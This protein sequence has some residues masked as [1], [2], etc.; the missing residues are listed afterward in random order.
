MPRAIRHIFRLLLAACLLPA[1]WGF[2]WGEPPQ[3]VLVLNSYD[4]GYAW[5]DA[6]MEGVRHVFAKEAPDVELFFEYMSTKRHP[7]ALSFPLLHDLYAGRY[8]AQPPDLVL[9][10][11]D[12]ALDFFLAYRNELFPGTPGVF[13]GIN[14]FRPQRLG[15]HGGV[16]GVA[17]DIAPE[18][19]L[20]LAA[21]LHPG[22]RE[23]FLVSDS[24]ATG[25]INLQRVL[26]VAPMFPDLRFT[27]LSG[28]PLAALQEKLAGLGRES[29]VLHLSLFLDGS[30]QPVS[31][32]EVQRLYR[33][34]A[35][36]PVY[37]MW[38]F[39]V[40]GAVLGG[41]VVSGRNQ[42]ESAARLALRVLAGE[43]PGDI[44]VQD[45]PNAYIFSHAALQRLAIP[46][47][48]L[49]EG[50]VVKGRPL[51]FY[52]QYK[53]LTWAAAGVFV[54]MALLVLGLGVNIVRRRRAEALSRICE[55]RFQRVF[56]SSP[57][58]VAISRY[59]DGR[60]L[61]VNDAFCRLLEYPRDKVLGETPETLGNWERPED[62]H[63]CRENLLREGECHGLETMLL[64]R[65][66]RS[67]PVLLSASLIDFGG[68]TCVLSV[69]NDITE[70]K[71]DEERLK[72]SLME[73]DILLKE[74]HHRVKNNLQ[75][76]SS[77]LSL[78]SAHVCDPNDYKLFLESRNRIG[79]MAL[80]HEE[81]YK[82]TDLS[83]V[84]VADYAGKLLDRLLHIYGRQEAV[85]ADVRISGICLPINL[86][87]P[88][89][90]IVNELATNALQHA[91]VHQEAGT[92]FL[93]LERR[94]AHFTLTVADDGSGFPPG[95]DMNKADTLGLQLVTSLVKQLRGAITLDRTAGPLAG[96]DGATGTTFT[97]HFSEGAQ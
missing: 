4:P 15:G 95:L 71:M 75:I 26:A 87:I 1:L 41:K 24:T 58:A 49:P 97:I 73:K 57:D 2:A 89:G 93:A 61:A 77:L 8:T 62:R 82:S 59:S 25:R 64:S 66:G 80:V 11:D 63:H 78:Q 55:E 79:S 68:E 56:Q 12:N 65:H 19:T 48:S 52:S 70:R 34:H 51:T 38:D 7:P 47:S 96:A 42:G 94:G 31:V 43:R 46:R 36:R 14:D 35:A 22:T 16:T 30:G 20:R 84:D 39:Y 69:A 92:V 13:C 88:F 72:A 33:E 28:L 6:I 21:R 83:R 23:V 86:A 60:Y 27:D 74:I 53:S 17:E 3:R 67:V 9:V 50:S 54:F 81:L 44:P 37:T 40:E 90:L 91:F 10:S 76:I 29:V 45:S 18:A 32:R 5:S 85:A